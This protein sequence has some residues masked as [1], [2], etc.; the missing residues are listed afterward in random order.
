MYKVPRVSPSALAATEQC[1]RFRPDGKDNDASI[2]GTL[3]HETME[4]LV[5]HHPPET[6]PEVI[7]KM[8]LSPDLRS[9]VLSA[10]ATVKDLAFAPEYTAVPAGR[11]ALPPSFQVY[12]NFRLRMR[13]GKPR[14]APL[15]PGVYPECEVDRG[16]NRHGYIDLMVV[17]PE[18][19]VFILDYKS[20]RASKNFRL[21]L[22]AYACDVNRL[23]PAH[24]SF[25][26]IIIAPRLGE[27][28]QLRME[29]G[30]SDLAVFR[31][32]I[33]RIE[34]LADRS[35]NDDEIPGHPCDA[36]QYCHWAGICKF[37]AEDAV[38]V[39]RYEPTVAR[40]VQ[41]GIY[42]GEPLTPETFRAP[43]TPAQRGLRRAVLKNLEAMIDAM[44]DGDKE[45]VRL[46]P[47]TEVPGWKVSFAKGRSVLDK[48]R[49]K[50]IRQAIMSR[51]GFTPEELA[52][53]SVVDAKL[54][55]ENLVTV[56]GYAKKAAAEEVKRCLE[57][58]S[59]AGS[60]VLRWTQVRDPASDVDAEFVDVTPREAI[61]N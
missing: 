9:L 42:A 10:S 11:N 19:L 39:A 38:A 43:A 58:F 49:M 14:V 57:P 45:W 26:C 30:P 35:A 34:E 60:P 13:G 53:V 48:T 40:L 56:C 20:N 28:D 61:G 25:V 47:T 16:Q 32:R 18:G 5:V 44:K 23:C 4:E 59:A 51:F 37:Q 46:N 3:F 54:L 29:L 1:P 27:E 50:D 8:E 22:A 52:D 55:E 6:W 41:R 36:C 15:K 24:D 17:T 2:D 31:R 12:P 21:Q 33:E 7:A